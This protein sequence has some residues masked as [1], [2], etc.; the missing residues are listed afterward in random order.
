M[1]T[2]K[3]LVKKF[4]TKEGKEFFSISK[5]GQYLP[6]ASVEPDKYYRVRL[7]GEAKM[8]SKEGIYEVAYEDNGL[9]LDNRPGVAKDIVRIK[10]V[11]IVFQRPLP[12]FDKDIRAAKD[13]DKEVK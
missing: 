7:C 10:A 8:P 6:I 11:R 5:E 3:L 12:V 9:W 4:V 13:I 1:N 2:I